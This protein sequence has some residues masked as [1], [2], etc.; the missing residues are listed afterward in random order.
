MTKL[1]LWYDWKC[2]T[3]ILVKMLFLICI[4]KCEIPFQ[5]WSTLFWLHWEMKG[6]CSRVNLVKRFSK[7]YTQ[8]V[9]FSLPMQTKM[10]ISILIFCLTNKERLVSEL[11]RS[12]WHQLE[13]LV[14]LQCWQTG[15][16]F[17]LH[18]HSFVRV[19]IYYKYWLS[20]NNTDIRSNFKSFIAQWLAHWLLE[21]RIV[22]SSPA[23]NIFFRIKLLILFISLSFLF[24]FLNFE[25]K[26]CANTCIYY[27]YDNTGSA[28]EKK[29]NFFIFQNGLLLHIQCTCRGKIRHIAW[30]SSFLFKVQCL[31]FL[32]END[33]APDDKYY[34]RRKR[35]ALW[36]W[37]HFGRTI[38]LAVLIDQ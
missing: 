22:C 23:I 38:T 34:L 18:W 37:Q 6:H 3:D 7:I 21:S 24:I 8:P 15:K 27:Q 4:Y 30:L 20:I 36:F 26:Q 31:F 35:N 25:V 13:L 9:S 10:C 17:R 28:M 12:D 19:Q 5:D 2:D 11:T 16:E 33:L 32:D 29:P 14:C 1:N